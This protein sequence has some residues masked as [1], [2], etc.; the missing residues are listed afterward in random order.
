ML[1]CSKPAG[2]VPF[3][4]RSV[5]SPLLPLDCPVMVRTLTREIERVGAYLPLFCLLLR[6]L[7]Y[8]SNKI[9]ATPLTTPA[10]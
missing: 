10:P 5:A 4:V 9:P 7:E 2:G 3:V 1:T 8:Q 6:V